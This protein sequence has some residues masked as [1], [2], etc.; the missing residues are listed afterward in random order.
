MSR[1]NARQNI[2]EET[3]DWV[4]LR[5]R[6]A[7][8]VER[9]QWELLAFVLMTNHLHLFVQTPQPNLSRGMQHFL[10][11]YANWFC[12]RHRRP[13]HL[14]QGRFKADLA[15]VVFRRKCFRGS[16]RTSNK[17]PL[18]SSGSQK[19]GFFEKPGFFSPEN[20]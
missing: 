6:L 18:R 15:E 12:R 16:T 2:V 1:G 17:Y 9:F 11:S 7:E 13:G 5:D 14:L 10:S 20:F 4:R 8:T 3:D 19:P